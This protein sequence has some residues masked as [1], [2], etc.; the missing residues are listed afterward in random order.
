MTLTE[1]LDKEGGRK[2]VP[3]IVRECV[4]WLKKDNRTFSENPSG[5]S[6]F[7]SPLGIGMQDEG[8][9]RLSCPASQLEAIKSEYSKSARVGLHR[10]SCDTDIPSR[11][12]PRFLPLPLLLFSSLFFLFLFFSIQPAL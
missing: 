11:F 5:F 1:A 3:A 7:V 8:I 12:F 10:L 6:Y 2:R 9:F 4:E